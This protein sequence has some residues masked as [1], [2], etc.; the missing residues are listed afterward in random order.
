MNKCKEKYNQFSTSALFFRHSVVWK[1]VRVNQVASVVHPHSNKLSN[2]VQQY[3][4]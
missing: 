3:I 4:R 1:M 2:N